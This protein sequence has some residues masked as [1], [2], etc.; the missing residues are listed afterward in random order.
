MTFKEAWEPRISNAHF[1]TT[2]VHNEWNVLVF[3]ETAT[4]SSPAWKPGTHGSYPRWCYTASLWLESGR[5]DTGRV[6]LVSTPVL[7]SSS[8]HLQ[9]RHTQSSHGFLPENTLKRL[10]HFVVYFTS[11]WLA[12]ETVLQGMKNVDLI[13]L[14]TGILPI[15]Q[16]QIQGL[17]KDFQ[18][19][20]KGYIRRTKLNQTDTFISINSRNL[21]M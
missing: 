11:Y 7:M 3:V 6:V 16:N 12:F 1:V 18:R 10:N 17:F 4:P 8:L 21:F 14:L 19:P 15:C 9:D 13:L 20:Y 2:V 5:V